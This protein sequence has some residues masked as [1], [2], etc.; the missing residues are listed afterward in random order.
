MKIH[1]HKMGQWVD[2]GPRRMDLRRVIRDR[3]CVSKLCQCD[4]DCCWET[5]AFSLDKNGTVN[6]MV[7]S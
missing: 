5:K 7:R 4:E 2:G 1:R 6:K 3:F